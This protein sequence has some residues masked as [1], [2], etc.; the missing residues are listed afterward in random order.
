MGA[1]EAREYRKLVLNIL[2]AAYFV[3]SSVTVR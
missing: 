2:C 3:T 1:K